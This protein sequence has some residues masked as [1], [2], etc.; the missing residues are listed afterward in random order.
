MNFS[1]L[2]IARVAIHVELVV[3]WQASPMRNQR[4][5]DEGRQRSR[6]LKLTQKM[7]FSDF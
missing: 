5:Q 7:T 1:V 6:F 2:S 3:L 4:D